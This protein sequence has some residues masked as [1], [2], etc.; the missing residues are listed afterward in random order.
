LPHRPHTHNK[1]SSNNRISIPTSYVDFSAGTR[2]DLESVDFESSFV[3]FNLVGQIPNNGEIAKIVRR[4]SIVTIVLKSYSVGPGNYYIEGFTY[5][6]QITVVTRDGSWEKE[7]NFVL[8]VEGG[9]IL[10]QEKH[11]VP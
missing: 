7:I 9:D 11:Y 3:I 5:P 1:F 8:E 2:Q 6:Y 10:A 4:G